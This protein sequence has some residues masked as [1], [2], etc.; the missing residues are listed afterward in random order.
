MTESRDVILKSTFG[1]LGA[2]L[3]AYV[4]YK[5][6]QTKQDNKEKRELQKYVEEVI[7]RLGDDPKKKQNFRN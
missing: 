5:T 4:G 6:I 3:L 1:I 2:A 7:R